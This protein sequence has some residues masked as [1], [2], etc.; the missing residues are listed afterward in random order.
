MCGLESKYKE[1]LDMNTLF[2]V[3]TSMSKLHVQLL[4]SSLYLFY[5]FIYFFFL[6]GG[7]CILFN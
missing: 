5:L 2:C 1:Q 4:K 6:G 7:L 3:T